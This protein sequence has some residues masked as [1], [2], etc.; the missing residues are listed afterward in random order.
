M[1]DANATQFLSRPVWRDPRVHLLDD[2]WL[3]TIFAVLFATAVPWLAS[4]LAIDVIAVAGGLVVLGAIHVALAALASRGPGSEPRRRL[5][6]ALHLG[7]VLAIAYIWPHA[8]GLQNPLFLVVFTLPIIG[9][10]FLSRWQPYVV[11]ALATIV[12]ALIAAVEAPELRWYA[13]G[14]DAVAGWLQQL[15]GVGS[16]SGALPFAGFYAPSDY[17]IVLLVGFAILMLACAVAAE[18][19]G[20]VF[21]RL[22]GQVAAALIEAERGQQLWSAVLERLPL[23][24]LVVDADTCEVCFASGT[25]L[26]LFEGVDGGVIGRNLFEA[27]RFSYPELVHELVSGVGGVATPCMLRL[28]GRLRVTEVRVQHLAQKGQRLALVILEDVTE[29]FCVKAALDVAEHAA[30]VVDARGRVRAWNRPATVLFPDLAADTEAAR[31]L[32]EASAAA[33]WW[34]PGLGGRRKAHVTVLQRVYQLTCSAVALPGEDE[35][36]FVAAFVPAALVAAA[37]QEDATLSTF[38]RR[39]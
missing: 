3:L 10:I 28:G 39:L 16:G 4:G 27:V 38:V 13:P 24:A 36:L 25:A 6:T 2:L 5:L 11:A 29:S 35:R 14:I 9:S 1:T 21:E 26:A 30:I 12:V 18:Y 23:P 17:F 33:T 37:D 15:L 32:P 34:D 19:L 20:T 7:G 22:Q 8:G 31:L